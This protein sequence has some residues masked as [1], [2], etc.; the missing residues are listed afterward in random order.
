VD[1]R[2]L[3][4]SNRLNQSIDE[5]RGVYYARM[6]GDDVAYPRRLER[7]VTYL[8]DHPEVD[9]VGAWAIIFCKGGVALGKRSG[10]EDH[11]EI[12]RRPR[13]GFPLIH[14]TYFGR[15]GFFQGLRYRS[16]AIRSEDQDM[17]LRAFLQGQASS[18]VGAGTEGGH[19]SASRPV[20]FANVPEIL[21]G[22]RE[23]G[24]DL[25]KNLRTRFYLTGCFAE[26]FLK[27]GR[28]F[29]A[30]RASAEQILKGL[31][32]VVAIG[33]G[34]GYSILP[35][36]ARPASSPE[37]SQWASVWAGLQNV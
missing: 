24:L 25:K 17:L 30:A 23:E 21:L 5:S 4:L 36:R 12:C 16:R 19:A 20:R 1:G 34:L 37:L 13:A 35:H 9:V 15:I 10:P 11:R 26:S 8:R 2:P 6:D 18:P 31:V 3:G 14:P 27:A 7:Q 32:D 33:T 29:A 22:Y 28:P